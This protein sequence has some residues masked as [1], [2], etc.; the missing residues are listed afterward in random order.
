MEIQISINRLLLILM[1]VH[2]SR[3]ATEMSQGSLSPFMKDPPTRPAHTDP[4][5]KFKTHKEPRHTL[6]LLSSAV[7]SLCREVHAHLSRSHLI[8]MG[9]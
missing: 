1:I 9:I 6:L 2:L 5:L 8:F 3:D 4:S 7:S